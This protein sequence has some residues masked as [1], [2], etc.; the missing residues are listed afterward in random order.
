MFE[1]VKRSRT[2]IEGAACARRR[3]RRRLLVIQTTL[4]PVALFFLCSVLATNFCPGCESIYSR[5]RNAITKLGRFATW[6]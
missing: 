3:V 1:G 6:R 5:W 2:L 4:R